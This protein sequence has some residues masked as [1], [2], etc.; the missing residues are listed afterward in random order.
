MNSENDV[1]LSFKTDTIRYYNKCLD[2]Q[3]IFDVNAG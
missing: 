3:N 2:K 1:R